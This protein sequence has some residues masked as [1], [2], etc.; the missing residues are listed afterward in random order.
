VLPVSL[1]SGAVGSHNMTGIP[2]GRVWVDRSWTGVCGGWRF[3]QRISPVNR[4]F[5]VLRV[6]VGIRQTAV[7]NHDTPPTFKTL[8][9]L[10]SE[11]AVITS[12][13]MDVPVS[14]DRRGNLDPR[15]DLV[16]D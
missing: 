14:I 16:L 5:N 6:P 2:G 3:V 9:T 13:E 8:K 12:W 4:V 11:F 10:R 7:Y 1:P 15:R